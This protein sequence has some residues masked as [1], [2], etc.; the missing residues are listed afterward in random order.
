MMRL[1]LHGQGIALVFARTDTSW[2]QE[3]V[4][5][6]ANGIFFVSQRIRFHRPDGTVGKYTGGAPSCFVAYGRE[7]A[8]RLQ[9]FTVKGKYVR[10]RP[11]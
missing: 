4:L 1:A 6:E 11:L 10:L 2:F 8:K 9:A 3:Y 5:G 7:A